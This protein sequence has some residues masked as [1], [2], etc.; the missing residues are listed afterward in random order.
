VVGPGRHLW[1]TPHRQAF[2]V[3][4]AGTSRLSPEQ[5]EAMAEAIEDGVELYFT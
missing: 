5:G 1:R 4:H 2:L 3:D